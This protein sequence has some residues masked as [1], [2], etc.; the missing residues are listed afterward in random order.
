M[1]GDRAQRS[2]VRAKRRYGG[3]DGE[4]R[5]AMTEASS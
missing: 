4:G 2:G 3:K 5:K 1:K